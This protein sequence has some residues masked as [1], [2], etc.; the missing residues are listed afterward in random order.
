MDFP[1]KRIACEGGGTLSCML[2]GHCY[3]SRN[4]GMEAGSA[5]EECAVV[6]NK[7][8]ILPKSCTNLRLTCVIPVIAVLDRRIIIVSKQHVSLME[9]NNHEP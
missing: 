3:S 2:T 9:G 8:K 7:E 6:N 5:G 4:I 1:P